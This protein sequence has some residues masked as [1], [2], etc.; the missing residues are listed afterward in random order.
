MSW[1]KADEIA[2]LEQIAE[3][4]EKGS[5]LASLFSEGMV[6]WVKSQIREDLGCDAYGYIDGYANQMWQIESWRNRSQAA[7]KRVEEL[8]V[9]MSDSIENEVL[10]RTDALARS[11]ER[12]GDQR[13]QA[14]RDLASERNKVQELYERLHTLRETSNELADDLSIAQGTIVALKAEL[15]GYVKAALV[16]REQESIREAR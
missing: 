8:L 4:S 16:Q 15:Y 11:V 3:E 10:E 1:S 6:K 7:E 5:Y 9:A 13:A 12:L 2:R 14:E